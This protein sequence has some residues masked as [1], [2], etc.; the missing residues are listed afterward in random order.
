[1]AVGEKVPHIGDVVCAIIEREGLFLIAQRP[2]GK[3]LAS[4]W[5][6]PGGKV[7]QNEP[8]E[9]ALQRELQEELGV[10]VKIIQRLTPCFHAY[11]DFSLT[12]IPY[13]CLLHEEEPRALEHKAL[14]WIS[15]DETGLYNFPDADLPILEEYLAQI[16]SS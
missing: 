16:R 12:L 9:A 8:E 1:M 14:R 10:T 11:R 6:F 3:S 2:E 4:L 5:E 7:N 13:R 15:L